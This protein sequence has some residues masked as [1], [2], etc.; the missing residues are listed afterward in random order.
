M[1]KLLLIHPN[2]VGDAPDAFDAGET[3]DPHMGQIKRCGKCGDAK[4]V[5]SFYRH[6]GRPDGRRSTCKRCDS[7]R[8]V[9]PMTHKACSKCGEEKNISL[10]SRKA[11]GV[12]GRRSECKTC[13][14]AHSRLTYARK[15]PGPQRE[16]RA[17]RPGFK[18][19]KKCQ[20]EHPIIDFHRRS[21]TGARRGV[22]KTCFNVQHHQWVRE[23]WERVRAAKRPQDAIRRARGRELLT[24]W[25]VRAVLADGT[26]LRH[27]QIPQS[28]VDLKREHLQIRRF[29]R[30]RLA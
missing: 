13:E 8:H 28:L 16:P 7:A 30:E 19:C 15:N 4:P 20:Q 18:Y 10:F 24:D 22:C 26:N 21:R 2:G 3:T 27:S 1:T 9:A 14:A 29:F 5:E 17:R 25:Y 23:N 6:T 11:G 12:G